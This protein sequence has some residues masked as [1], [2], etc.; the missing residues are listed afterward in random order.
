[1]TTLTRLRVPGM[2]GSA[3]VSA[4]TAHLKAVPGVGRMTVQLN[5][6]EPSIISIMS[7]RPLD[8]DAIDAA[9]SAAGYQLFDITVIE[10]AIAAE[11]ADQAPARQALRNP[12]RANRAAA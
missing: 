11:R 3:S 9:I 12:Y 6:S 8:D 5:K 4:V 7:A 2:L 10:D 1:M